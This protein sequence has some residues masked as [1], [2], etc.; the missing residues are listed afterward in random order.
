MRIATC[1]IRRAYLYC[2]SK[3]DSGTTETANL[4]SCCWLCSFVVRIGQQDSFPFVCQWLSRWTPHKRYHKP[5]SKNKQRIYHLWMWSPSC[6]SIC[7]VAEEGGVA[8]AE[9]PSGVTTR[10]IRFGPG[11]RVSHRWS[12]VVGLTSKQASSRQTTHKNTRPTQQHI[13][14]AK[15]DHFK[16]TDG[17]ITKTDDDR[18]FPRSK[19]RRRRLTRRQ[20]DPQGRR[21]FRILKGDKIPSRRV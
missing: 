21:S 15:T 9:I 3:D 16:R 6:L 14:E 18:R 4:N 19:N 8:S 1:S 10:R 13:H 12:V 7:V 20:A 2:S 17:T 11:S 5:I